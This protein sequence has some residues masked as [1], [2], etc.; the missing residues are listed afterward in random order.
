MIPIINQLAH[1]CVS[2][3]LDSRSSPIVYITQD[4]KRLITLKDLS[5]VAE[6]ISIVSKILMMLYV[7]GYKLRFVACRV[8]SS[9]SGLASTRAH[10]IFQ[11]STS[12]TTSTFLDR[13]GCDGR[14]NVSFTVAVRDVEGLGV[15]K[16]DG[17]SLSFTPGYQYCP[18][19]PQS[20][21]Q[22]VIYCT[23]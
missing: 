1:V 6:D 8:S 3:K 10:P 12:S 18:H 14:N 9:P 11:Q 21:K 23:L 22:P 15:S 17:C 5:P 7:A 16:V 4:F 19:H 13:Y 2:D 20:C